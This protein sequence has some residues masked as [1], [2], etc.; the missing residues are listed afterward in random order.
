[1]LPTSGAVAVATD[2][3]ESAMFFDGATGDIFTADAAAAAVEATNDV[4]AVALRRRRRR[5]K[6]NPP[7]P[8]AP[9][10]PPGPVEPMAIFD[11]KVQ[12]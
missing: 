12:P 2:G 9:A 10:P 7:S 1:M 5:R 3:S 6:K 11:G 8:P 4:H